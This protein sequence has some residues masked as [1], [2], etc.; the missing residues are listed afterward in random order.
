MTVLSRAAAQIQAIDD[1]SQILSRQK[2]ISFNDVFARALLKVG[3]VNEA[4]EYAWKAS[5]LNENPQTFDEFFKAF[6]KR[7]QKLEKYSSGES[8]EQLVL[9]LSN[10]H[11]DPDSLPTFEY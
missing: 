7:Y 9:L 5:K 11:A 2:E 4:K 1:I 8:Q 6:D 3:R 10:T